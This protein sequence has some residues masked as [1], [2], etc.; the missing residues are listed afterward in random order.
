MAQVV[1]NPEVRAC[2]DNPNLTAEQLYGLFVSLCS[3]DLDAG[4]QNFV[5]VLIANDRRALLPEIR[6]Q[7]EALKHGREGLVEA[8]ITSAF[9]LDDSPLD[10]HAT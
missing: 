6:S 8:D 1:V 7:F 5:R 10:P 4:A 3:D 9:A 2:V